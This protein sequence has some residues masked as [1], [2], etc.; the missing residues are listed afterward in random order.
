MQQE[1]GQVLCSLGT[2]SRRALGYRWGRRSTA[3]VPPA[4]RP[5]P[6][7]ADL[8]GASN[9]QGEQSLRSGGGRGGDQRQE[10]KFTRRDTSGGRQQLGRGPVWGRSRPQE[11]PRGQGEV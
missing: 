7:S 6:S 9:E 1:A 4:S 2:H 8:G 10:N 11:A 5:P 3:F